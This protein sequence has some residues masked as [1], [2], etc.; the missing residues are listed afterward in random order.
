LNLRTDYTAA[1][2]RY[3][4]AWKNKLLPS[5]L[6]FNFLLAT[7]A[8]TPSQVLRPDSRWW[9]GGRS[10]RTQA[11]SGD[12]RGLTHSRKGSSPA[13]IVFRR[14]RK[15]IA[16]LLRLTSPP[17]SRRFAARPNTLRQRSAHHRLPL[18]RLRNWDLRSSNRS[19]SR[20]C[21]SRF[22]VSR[23]ALTHSIRARPV[24]R[25]TSVGNSNCGAI[26]TGKLSEISPARGQDLTDLVR[27]EDE[28][29][30]SAATLL[31]S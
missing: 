11:I 23:R 4:A 14:M 24:R 13:L 20:R 8:S 10:L 22:S 16:V 28:G 18:A 29:S 31:W 1:H 25:H 26:T 2:V 12:R 6:C 19:R 7:G 15:I 30:R 27:M 17:Q 5:T 3:I 9:G 21:A